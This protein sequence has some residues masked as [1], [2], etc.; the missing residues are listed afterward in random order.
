MNSKISVCLEVGRI[1]RPKAEYSL[2]MLLRPL[3]LGPIFVSRGE[4]RRGAIYYGHHPSGLPSGTILFPLAP[5]VEAFFDGFAPLQPETVKWVNHSGC[6]VPI[7]FPTGA[8]DDLVASAFYWLS[9]W[10]EHVIRNRDQHGRF[11]YNKSLQAALKVAHIPV[12]DCYR[13]MLQDQL[14]AG[15]VV[16]QP[17]LWA[18]KGWAFCPTIDVDY[19]RHWR[20]GMIFREKVEYF[21]LNHRKVTLGER[22]SRLFQFIKSFFTPGDAFQTALHRMHQVIRTHG[23]ATVFFKAAAHGPNDVN[24]RLDQPFLH[25]LL[26]NLRSDKFEVGLHPSYHAHTHSGYLNGERRTLASL[27]GEAPVSVRQHF[28][29]YEPMITPRIQVGAGFRIDSSLGF[30][31][32]A[33]FRNA[34]CMPFLKFDCSQNTVMEL[35]E[36]PVLLMDGALFNREKYGVSEAVHK[37]IELLKMCQKFGG[38]GVALWH[39]VIGEEMDYP[40]WRDHFE[41]I[42]RWSSTEGAYIASL[43]DALHAWLGYPVR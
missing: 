1:Y 10:Q 36:M 26:R 16:T 38:V 41:E 15:G 24:Y 32:C 28:L 19:L 13:V 12:V 9:G 42:I 35:W 20:L 2:R 8:G 27:T 18:G 22:W 3:G 40:G 5:K 39:N 43:K 34:T 23:N 29:R 21:L 25:Q 11:P 33:G 17:R 4:L 6:K 31:E 37:S 7:L 30:A 14:V